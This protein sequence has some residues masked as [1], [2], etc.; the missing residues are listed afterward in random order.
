MWMHSPWYLYDLVSSSISFVLVYRIAYQ[1]KRQVLICWWL[2]SQWWVMRDFEGSKWIE[3]IY[4]CCWWAS[5]V[6]HISNRNKYLASSVKYLFVKYTNCSVLGFNEI[7][8]LVYH[9]STR[10]AEYRYKRK[11]DRNAYLD[12]VDNL[13]FGSF[14]VASVYDTNDIA[15]ISLNISES[16]P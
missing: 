3:D 9:K 16:C 15:E 10:D 8:K 1:R 6:R 7:L 2:H 12:F 5:V 4:K 14:N 13:L 11:Y